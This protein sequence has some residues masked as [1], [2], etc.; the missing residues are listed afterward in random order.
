[1]VGRRLH[2]R[3]RGAAIP[4]ARTLE[5]RAAARRSFILRIALAVLMVVCVGA[6]SAASRSADAP[7]R[8]LLLGQRSVIVVLDVSKSIK[9][10][11]NRTIVA[12]V[13][14]L[15]DSHVHVGLVAFS[16]IAYELLPPGSPARELRPLLRYFAPPPPGQQPTLTPWSV[17]FSGGTQISAGLNFAWRLL[18]R[19]GN[20]HSP[21]LLLSDLDTT[22]DDVP[23]VAQTFTNF[24]KHHVRFRI[25]SLSPQ[26]ADASLFQNLAGKSAFTRPIGTPGGGSGETGG[27]LGGATPWFLLSV[28][29][30]LLVALAAN[31]HWCG[32]LF[33]PRV[34]T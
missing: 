2:A 30:V 23:R 15:I 20:P 8:E 16:D 3:I 33:V 18:R 25:V 32:R 4:L 11:A 26:P 9:P 6:A 28:I 24:R 12:V 14:D 22:P 1:M 7:A 17:G 27:G 13:K 21:L 34:E 31:E 5:L 19:S 10:A 29:L